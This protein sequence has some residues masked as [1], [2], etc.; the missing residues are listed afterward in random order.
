MQSRVVSLKLPS[1]WNDYVTMVM[2]D[3]GYVTKGAIYGLDGR[4][5]AASK[6][7]DVSSEEVKVIVNGFTDPSKLWTK[8][9][10]VCGKMYTC[11]R[12]DCSVVVG[13]DSADGSGCV[14]YKCN[15]CLLVAVHEEGA[16]PGG[17][18]N[19]MMKLGEYLKDQGV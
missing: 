4:R 19:L 14:I 8:G 6:G 16:H 15:K 5:W 7:F 1:S 3:S 17:C 18:H 9:V 2:T 10:C 11:T 13:R 12:T